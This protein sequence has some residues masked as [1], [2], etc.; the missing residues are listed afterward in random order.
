[1]P[2]PPRTTTRASGPRRLA[3]GLLLSMSVH[4]LISLVSQEE[5]TPGP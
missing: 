5:L 3:S 4:I 2:L 1:L